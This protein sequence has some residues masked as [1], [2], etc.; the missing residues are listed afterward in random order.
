M[1]PQWHKNQ[2]F[3]I[4]LTLRFSKDLVELG[5]QRELLAPGQGFGSHDPS[6]TFTDTVDNVPPQFR[7]VGA[8]V[9]MQN[10]AG[11]VKTFYVTKIEGGRLTVDGNHP[12][13]GRELRV[14]VDI[15]EVRDPTEQEFAQD[16]MAQTGPYGLH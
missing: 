10:E 1:Q 8:E 12:L 6:L 5:V 4:L 11:D 2:F 16:G 9:Q 13:A 3:R 15:K 7:H 14:K